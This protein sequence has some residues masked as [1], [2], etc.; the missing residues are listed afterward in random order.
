M[1]GEGTGPSEVRA[2]LSIFGAGVPSKRLSRFL[3]WKVRST[4]SGRA[5]G[6][7]LANSLGLLATPCGEDLR[8]ELRPR[9]GKGIQQL[10]EM[11]YFPPPS[12]VPLPLEIV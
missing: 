1:V 6:K 8:S 3:T 11:G 5:D 4:I 7:V 10:P 2:A 12:D 9:F